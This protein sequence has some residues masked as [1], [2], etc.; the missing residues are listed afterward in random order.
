[1]LCMNQFPLTRL[2]IGVALLLISITVVGNA[3]PAQQLELATSY[4]NSR[5]ALYGAGILVAIGVVATPQPTITPEESEASILRITLGLN[6]SKEWNVTHA[7]WQR[8][9]ETIRT[10][11]PRLR[12]AIREDARLQNEPKFDELLR[13]KFE[14]TINQELSE[15]ELQSLVDFYGSPVGIRFSEASKRIDEV[16][17]QL[18]ARDIVSR[19]KGEPWDFSSLKTFREMP[20][21]DCDVCSPFFDR[22]QLGVATGFVPLLHYNE[23]TTAWQQLLSEEDRQQIR[24]FHQS[25]LSERERKA[26]KTASYAIRATASFKEFKRVRDEAYQEIEAPYLKHWRELMQESRTAMP[27]FESDDHHQ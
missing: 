26:M 5:P 11:I 3:E 7:N 14:Q 22:E 4:L 8:V 24:A 1:M 27:L 13:G 25:E 16:A 9:V 23:L 6:S 15:S 21:V 20:I 18:K 12:Q 17:N 2:C 19:A 10:D